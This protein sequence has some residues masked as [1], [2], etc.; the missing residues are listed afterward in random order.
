MGL[1]GCQMYAMTMMLATSDTATAM[2]LSAKLAV[3]LWTSGANMPSTR[4]D[5][6]RNESTLIL[7]GAMGPS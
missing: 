1:S 2:R 3:C 7:M 5:A 6:R 4:R